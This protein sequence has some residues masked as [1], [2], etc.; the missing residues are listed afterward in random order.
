MRPSSGAV[1]LAVVA[2]ALAVVAIA[3]PALAAQSPFGVLTPDGGG[4]GFGGPLAPLFA[5]IREWQVEL[6]QLLR[7]EMAALKESG[8]S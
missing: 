6:N 1:F 3:A 7:G 2:A 8:A 4:S 5:W